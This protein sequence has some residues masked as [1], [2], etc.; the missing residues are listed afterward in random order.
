LELRCAAA[1]RAIIGN[2]SVNMTKPEFKVASAGE[3]QRILDAALGKQRSEYGAA[4]STF[5]ALMFSLRERGAAVLKEPDCLRRLGECLPTQVRQ[6][7][8][9]LDRLRPKY[10]AITDELLL[11]LA[12]RI[13]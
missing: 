11:Q 5:E 13:P 10:T 2:D 7:I 4:P 9:R 3:L 6:V 8:E 1:G 12:E